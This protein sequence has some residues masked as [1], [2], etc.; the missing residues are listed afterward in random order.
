MLKNIRLSNQSPL[1]LIVFAV[2]LSAC[3]STAIAQTEIDDALDKVQNLLEKQRYDDAISECHKALET[4]PAHPEI[5]FLLGLAY[6]GLNDLRLAEQSLIQTID[7]GGSRNRVL[8]AL[9]R[10][11][12]EQKEYQRL[13][14]TITSSTHDSES[15]RNDI[16]V[17]RSIAKGR[18]HLRNAD[19]HEAI[20]DF[21]AALALQAENTNA[22][23]GRVESYIA[24]DEFDNALV[25]VEQLTAIQPD[26]L[27]TRLLNIQVL[28][29]KNDFA[30][31]EEL[32]QQILLAS[33]TEQTLEWLRELWNADPHSVYTGVLLVNSYLQ[34]YNEQQTA[35]QIAKDVM[36]YHSDHP[37]ALRSLGKALLANYQTTEALRICQRLTDIQPHSAT[38]W[39]L[40]ASA[41]IQ[42]EN[43]EKANYSLLQALELQ[44][45]YV[46]AHRL[47]VELAL[48]DERYIDALSNARK[49]QL[50]VPEQGVGHKLEG[51]VYSARQDYHRA[52]LAYQNAYAKTPSAQLA[53]FLSNAQYLAEKPEQ[54]LITLQKWLAVQPSDNIVRMQLAMLLDQT[55]HRVDA[56]AEYEQLIEQNP[57][58]VIALNNL[59]WLYG[60]GH[61]KG[62]KYAK[63]A[64]E[65]APDQPEVLDTLGWLL[66]KS[67]KTKQGLL[68]LQQATM[69][70]PHL[71]DIRYHLALAYEKLGRD[72]EARQEL[73]GLLSE[74]DNPRFGKIE[75][76]QKLLDKLNQ[77]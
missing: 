37:L 8:P 32:L 12:L 3:I 52:I 36:R 9:G 60:T 15:L 35:L 27:S 74:S 21:T 20:T 67:Q 38:N 76:A 62:L 75:E 71:A 24:I 5:H 58:N 29:G 56:I 70:A 4:A 14:D 22:L 50:L 23:L 59:A 43:K 47:F 65:L 28:L 18:I 64:V 66:V 51:D 54:A 42:Q 63:R 73:E 46:P 77:N 34:Q 69:L 39:T 33:Q 61:E 2:S 13:L 57:H 19:Y 41:H 68:Y 26:V 1:W 6:L 40:L 48:D 10:V 49:V 25:D 55:G 16:A 53:L 11:L 44:P 17:L 31:A 30:S 7:L 45:N 72:E